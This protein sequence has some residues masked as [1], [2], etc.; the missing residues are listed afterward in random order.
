MADEIV[1]NCVVTVRTT[2][3]VAKERIVHKVIRQTPQPTRV[4]STSRQ[5]PP[6]PPGGEGPEGPAAPAGSFQW[7]S[8]NW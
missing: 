5:G 6:G 8:T 7:N 3:I 1:K 4:I 2:Q